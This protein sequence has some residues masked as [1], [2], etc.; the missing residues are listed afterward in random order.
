MGESSRVLILKNE[1][2]AAIGWFHAEADKHKR[3]Y[4]Q[5][6]YMVFTLT[7]LATVLAAAGSAVPESYRP[8]M[9]VL[10]VVVTATS[11][12]VTA[13][14]GLRKP[15]DLWQNERSFEYA[16]LDLQRDLVFR[17]AEDASFEPSEHFDRLQEI[18]RASGDKWLSHI[19]TASQAEK[20]REG[21]NTGSGSI[22]RLNRGT[23]E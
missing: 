13:L 10:V 23:A 15:G 16:L 11:G 12:V 20:L 14:E 21:R 7:A 5:Y 18:L 22:A 2:A 1:L 9:N 3:L 4:R 8:S 19:R 17:S 6:R